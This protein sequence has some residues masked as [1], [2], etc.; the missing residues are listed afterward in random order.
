MSWSKE[1]LRA[2]VAERGETA[3]GIGGLLLAHERLRGRTEED[4]PREKAGKELD[5]LLERQAAPLPYESAREY[6]G[7]KQLRTYAA[8]KALTRAMMQSA[9]K[10]KVEP[11]K[12]EAAKQVES[13]YQRREPERERG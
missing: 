10:D 3:V 13:A 4:Y 11:V 1:K 12:P 9:A 6:P 5:A 2:L 8:D 7:L